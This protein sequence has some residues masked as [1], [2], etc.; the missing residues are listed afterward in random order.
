MDEPL[1]RA[2]LFVLGLQHVL[3]MYAGNVTVPLLVAG[4]LELSAEQTAFLINSDLFAAGLAT[5][6]QTVGI[7]KGMPF[8]TNVLKSG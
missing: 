1:G 2:R 7:W 8:Q 4:A 6:I 3:V 5:L